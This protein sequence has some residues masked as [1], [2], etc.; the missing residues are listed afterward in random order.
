MMGSLVYPSGLK[1]CAV[2]SESRRLGKTKLGN[3]ILDVFS[4]GFR[5]FSH[6][7]DINSWNFIENLESSASFAINRPFELETAVGRLCGLRRPPL[8]ISIE[9]ISP[10]TIHRFI[11]DKFPA[12]WPDR[13]GF[14]GGDYQFSTP[15][16][17]F[18]PF[19]PIFC[20]CLTRLAAKRVGTEQGRSL[21]TPNV[22]NRIKIN[23][24][25]SPGDPKPR[26]GPLWGYFLHC[27]R[28]SATRLELYAICEHTRELCECFSSN[29]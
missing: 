3:S 28:P 22:K 16:D 2:N 25:L 24:I 27:R 23:R 18:R 15:N 19:W 21:A 1:N 5:R 12:F 14:T 7:M 29:I 26:W 8:R 4:S 11:F 10:R 9:P 20:S 13:F 6:W 17:H